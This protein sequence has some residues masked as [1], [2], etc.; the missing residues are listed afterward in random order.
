MMLNITKAFEKVL[1]SVNYKPGQSIET[2]AQ[3]VPIFDVSNKNA[4]SVCNRLAEAALGYFFTSKMG[5]ANFYGRNH[6]AYTDHAI[7][8]AEVLK[9]IVVSQPWDYIFN[10]I[11][12][13]ARRPIKKQPSVIYFLPNPVYI[14]SGGSKTFHLSYPPSS[15]VSIAFISANSKSTGDGVSKTLNLLASSFSL[16]T[17]GGSLVLSASANLWV[18]GLEIR[19]GRLTRWRKNSSS[20]LPPVSR[21]A[22]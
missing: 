22:G 11:S 5:S 9:T 15:D 7:G 16:G 12:V 19:A 17:S 1:H 20:R 18:T 13:K 8:Q 4:G 2:D 6:A 14:A 21:H 3:P 10:H